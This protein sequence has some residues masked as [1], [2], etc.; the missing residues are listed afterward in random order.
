M[1]ETGMGHWH[2][3]SF[4]G[5]YLPIPNEWKSKIDEWLSKMGYHFAIDYFKFPELATKG[6]NIELELA[7]D[8]IG[9][10]PLY[11]NVPLYIRLCGEKEYE[12]KTDVNVT[13][14]L[15]GKHKEI[16]KFLLTNDIEAG[17]YDIELGIFGQNYPMVYFATD[18]EK[19]GKFYRV[20]KM[21][22]E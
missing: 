16:I 22:V 6:E 17:E 19:N 1:E 15:P 21:M 3:S 12:I 11:D 4:N 8:N 2:V 10:A 14:W 20:G 9:V 18:A 13:A 7:I 5:K